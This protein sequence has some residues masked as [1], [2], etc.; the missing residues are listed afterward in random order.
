[1]KICRLKLYFSFFS[2]LCLVFLFGATKVFAAT[3]YDQT[4]N[5]GT[6]T[7]LTPYTAGDNHATLIGNFTLSTTATLTASSTAEMTWWTDINAVAGGNWNFAVIKAANCSTLTMEEISGGVGTGTCT[8]TDLYLMARPNTGTYNTW[9]KAELS[10]LVESTGAITGSATGCHRDSWTAGTYS[11]CA[12][13]GFGSTDHHKIKTNAAIQFY[14]FITDDGTS[15]T[16]P[17]NVDDEII[18]PQ[19]YYTGSLIP[20]SINIFNYNFNQ[21]VQVGTGDYITAALC[22]NSSCSTTTPVVFDNG[23]ATSST[24]NIVRSPSSS[25]FTSTPALP[26][27]SS[28]FTLRAPTDTIGTTTTQT[29]FYKITPVYQIALGAGLQGTSSM[30]VVSWHNENAAITNIPY[31]TTTPV[32]DFNAHSMACPD[33]QWNATSTY[34]GLNGTLLKCEIVEGLLNMGQ[35]FVNIIQ[36]AAKKVMDAITFLFPVNLI[37]NINNSWT[38]SASSTIPTAISWLTSEIDS[39]GNIT[40]DPTSA[41]SSST[42]VILTPT[43]TIIWGKDMGG[44]SADWEIW[45]LRIRDLI[46]YIIWGA[47][48]YFQVI[49]RAQRMFEYFRNLDSDDNN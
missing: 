43:P 34:L 10:N 23:V 18:Y 1:M 15:Y 27:G 7:T 35:G 38:E 11:I 31:S 40:L 42:A 46:G 12:Y 33:D 5:S 19:F 30:F 3:I 24:S 22:N 17:T 29:L 2:L 39:D 14:G 4:T 44:T 41:F 47:V 32:F 36:A 48:I 9:I 25:P 16:P 6:E 13:S 21:N 37:V 20:D 45:R 28:F 26:Y 8:A 49:K